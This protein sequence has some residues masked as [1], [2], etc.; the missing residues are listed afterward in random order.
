MSSSYFTDVYLDF[1]DDFDCLRT[2][3]RFTTKELAELFV[4]GVPL[5]CS[6]ITFEAAR[7]MMGCEVYRPIYSV[8]ADA[9]EDAKQFA[10]Y[11]HSKEYIY[12]ES[13]W[14]VPLDEMDNVY[15]NNRL[16]KLENE[17][18]ELK[19]KVQELTEKLEALSAS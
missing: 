9:I 13:V 10:K 6:D 11:Y 2:R 4:E 14:L 19:Q 16:N 7:I 12:H 3:F 17:N 1:L 8:L 15:K 18:E 5:L